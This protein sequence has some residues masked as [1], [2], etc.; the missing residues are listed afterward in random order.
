MNAFRKPSH[1]VAR[2]AVLGFCSLAVLASSASA[3][4]G[5]ATLTFKELENKGTV[6]YVDNAP[7]ATLKDGVVSIS[8]GDQL[9]FSTPIAMEGKV[10]GKDRIVC[11]ATSA[12]TTKKIES[13]GFT[14]TGIAKIP[15]GTLILVGEAKEGPTEGAITGGTGIYAGARGTFVSRQG[16]GSSTTTVSLLE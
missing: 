6:H 14:C 2:A 5:P 13:A 8:A 7:K 9:V 4:G 12:G 11:T 3:I 1:L 16:R 10:V 15:G